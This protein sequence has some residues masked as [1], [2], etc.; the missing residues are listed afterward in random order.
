[1]TTPSPEAPRT[2]LELIDL[3]TDSFVVG[4]APFTI[5]ELRAVERECDQRSGGKSWLA[6]MIRDYIETWRL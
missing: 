6:H 5:D 3:I 4:L 1:M 2:V